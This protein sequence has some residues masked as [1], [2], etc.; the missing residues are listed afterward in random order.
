MLAGR[1]TDKQDRIA[2]VKKNSFMKWP[3][4]VKYK[5]KYYEETYFTRVIN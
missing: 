4:G 2:S 5:N 3:P 1:R